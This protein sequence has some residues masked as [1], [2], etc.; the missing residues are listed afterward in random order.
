MGLV[1]W[2][3]LGF[4]AGL[5]GGALTGA[6]QARGCLPRIVVGILGA[7]IGG[8]LARAAGIGT[9]SGVDLGSVAIAA[10][11]SVLLLLVLEAI[12]RR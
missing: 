6:R 5:I 3:V 11:G 9:I 1:S 2:I 12:E 8:A 4:L 10:A 7:L